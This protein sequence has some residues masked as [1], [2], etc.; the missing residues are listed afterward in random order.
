MRRRLMR[1]GVRPIAA[2]LLASALIAAGCGDDDD[3]PTTPTPTTVETGVTGTEG[4]AGSD[5]LLI[6][7][8][9][10]LCETAETETNLAT[11]GLDPNDP[12]D[13]QQIADVLVP[14]GQGLVDGILAT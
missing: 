9:D 5:E 2:L 8:V 11:E 10:A 4:E 6:A 14:I 7:E 13:Q 1:F 3:E 12:Q